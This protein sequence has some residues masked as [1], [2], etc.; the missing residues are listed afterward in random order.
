MNIDVGELFYAAPLRQTLVL[1]E[2]HAS[3]SMYFFEV[4]GGRL[5]G[6][7]VHLTAEALHELLARN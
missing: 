4:Y 3:V 1:R 5:D 2:K 6:E 7:A